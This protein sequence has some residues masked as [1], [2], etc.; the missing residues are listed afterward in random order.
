MNILVKS[1][2]IDETIQGIYYPGEAIF[3]QFSEAYGILGSAMPLTENQLVKHARLISLA[4]DVIKRVD[5]F[6]DGEWAAYREA[7]ARE[8]ILLLGG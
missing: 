8:E 4:D 3:V 2:F 6:M 1:L 5:R 7:V